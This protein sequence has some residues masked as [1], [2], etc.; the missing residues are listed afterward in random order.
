MVDH[1]A[2]VVVDS[3]WR[4]QSLKGVAAWCAVGSDPVSNIK[5]SCLCYFVNGGGSDSCFASALRWARLQGSR[6]VEIPTLS[7]LE[8]VHALQCVAYAS[9]KN[10]LIFHGNQIVMI[11][12]KI[13]LAKLT[14]MDF[15]FG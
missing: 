7:L 13:H 5:D 8:I 12:M 3:T 4:R 1:V 6:R 15:F 9:Y 11:L 2:R 14:Q 10:Y